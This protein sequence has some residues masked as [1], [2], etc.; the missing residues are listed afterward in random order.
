MRQ[1]ARLAGVSLMTVS[2]ALRNQPRVA[3]KTRQKILKIAQSVGYR[4]D[5][6][7]SKLMHHLRR[8]IRPQFQS[9][10]CGLTNWPD[11]VKPPYF[12]T[13]LA[14]AERQALARGYG[15]SVLPF[16]AE[17]RSGARLRRLMLSQGVQGVMLLPQRPPLDLTTLLD[18]REFSVAASSLSVLGPEVNRVAPHHFSN[19][20]RLCRELTAL[21]YRRI[22]LVVDAEQDMRANRGFSA[23]LLSF[24]RHEA[25]EPVPPLVF[26]GELAAALV[27]WFRRERPDAI[28]ATS[29]SHVRNYARLLNLR[30]PGPVGFASLNL[31]AP[32]KE[33]GPIAG[34]DER[35]GEIGAITVDLLAAMIERRVRGLP[36]EPVSTLLSGRWRA[37][38]SC[39]RRKPARVPAR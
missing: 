19:T 35:P 20:V 2:R 18:W 9:T 34:I 14:G 21:G 10:I 4:P 12:Q 13:L 36:A 16:T 22:G 26:D 27:P 30:L 1:I 6:E 25:T 33:P 32:A 39:P 8:G 7:I 38:A 37:G 11:A 5:P 17:A 15:F 3:E 24:G 28:V 23:A 31:A 29:E